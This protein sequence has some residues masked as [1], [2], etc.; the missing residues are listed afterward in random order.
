MEDLLIVY[1]TRVDEGHGH[2]RTFTNI[3]DK[4][5]LKSVAF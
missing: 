4:I 2:D 3:Y 5:L 1:Y